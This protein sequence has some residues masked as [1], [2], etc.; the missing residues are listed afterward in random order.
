M[1]K[2]SLIVIWGFSVGRIPNRIGTTSA[3]TVQYSN[4]LR[5]TVIYK[6]RLPE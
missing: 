1:N 6:K 5:L 3:V 4:Q 2:K